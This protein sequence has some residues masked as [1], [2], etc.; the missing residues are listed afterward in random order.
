MCLEEIVTAT[1]FLWYSVC[2]LVHIPVYYHSR[3]TLM[4][5]AYTRGYSFR[6]VNATEPTVSAGVQQI[7]PVT[8]NH[9]SP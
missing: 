9:T 6:M 8:L 5:C 1:L 2:Y 3:F 7:H 4:R